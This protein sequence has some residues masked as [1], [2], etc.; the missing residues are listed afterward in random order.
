MNYFGKSL[1]TV[2]TS[3]LSGFYTDEEKLIKVMFAEKVVLKIYEL[4]KPEEQNWRWEWQTQVWGLSIVYTLLDVQK[5]DFPN[6]VASNAIRIP[7]FKI[8]DVDACLF[9]V[10][11]KTLLDQWTT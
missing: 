11:I 6:F 4:K 9:A 3:L 5:A 7:A 2:I 1:K 10:N 8:Q